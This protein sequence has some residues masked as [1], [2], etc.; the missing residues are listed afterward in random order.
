M[1]NQFLVGMVLL[2]VGALGL[3]YGGFSYTRDRHQVDLGVV[4]FTVDEKARVN[5]PLWAGIGLLLAGGAL[6][7]NGKKR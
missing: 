1:N 3:A 5:V 2:V 6:L 4:Q 7:V